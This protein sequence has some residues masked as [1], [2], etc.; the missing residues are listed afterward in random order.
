[1]EFKIIGIITTKN[2]FGFLERALDSAKNQ[3]KIPCEII[4]SSDSDDSSSIIKERRLAEQYN[5][6]Y[7]VNNHAHN[8]SGV[9]NAAVMAYIKN[10]LQSV[11]NFDKTYIAFLDDDD[12]WDEY[13][14]EKCCK[15]I[16]SLPDF[17]VTGLVYQDANGDKTLSIPQTIHTDDFLKGN[18]HIQGS[19]M[20]IKLTTILKCGMFDENMASSVD[21][22]IFV[23]IMQL[24]PTYMIIN[25]HLVYV[26]VSNDRKR[27]TN[28]TEL[29]RRDLS[30]FF[31]KYANIMSEGVKHNFF[32]RCKKLFGIECD[33][34]KKTTIPTQNKVYFKQSVDRELRVNV[35]NRRLIVGIVIT[36]YELG[37]RL[38]ED[39]IGLKYNNIKIV[40]VKNY[41]EA[42]EE[43]SLLLRKSGIYYYIYDCN[44]TIREIC[45]TR[46]ILF[47]TLYEESDTNDI[48]WILDDDMQLSYISANGNILK[49]DIFNVISDNKDKYDAIVGDYTL[50]PPLP[51]LSTLRTKLLDYVYFHV[52]KYQGGI[53]LCDLRDYY[54]DLSE[55]SPEH[56]ETP[57]VINSST[58][59]KEIFSGKATSRPLYLNNHEAL[60]ASN[61]GGNVLIFNREL[62]KVKH[63]SLSIAE[64]TGRRSDYFWVLE[65]IRQGYSIKNISYATLH[66]RIVSEF[67]YER[68]VNK[69]FRDII[70]SSCTKTITKVGLS[71]SHDLLSKTFKSIFYDR[72]TKFVVSYYRIMGLLKMLNDS[73]YS[74]YFTTSNLNHFL[75]DINRLIGE[76]DLCK[77]WEILIDK[78][79]DY[80]Q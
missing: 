63:L 60:P 35:I 62:L 45:T 43:L 27:V 2:R 37:L 19:N 55:R 74:K 6:L 75:V 73:F 3:S 12:I 26:N 71:A 77:E 52:F 44:K 14:I 69:L 80:E 24:K 46:N 25:E 21:R 61:C 9:R 8:C 42:S 17:I 34:I 23:R 67:K 5:V 28:S 68:E 65:S 13:Y 49:T 48:V 57:F 70:G 41:K 38:I 64:N 53:E 30:I 20:F 4:I 11:E 47:Q 79:N 56:L 10:N 39:I 50:D 32:L 29:K 40:I 7:L 72:V 22:D 15:H 36:N 58:S 59:L 33:D 31:S 54:Y 51:I 78:I 76:N 1:M 66:N 16:G 18:P